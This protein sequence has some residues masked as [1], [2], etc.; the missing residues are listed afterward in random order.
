MEF[1]IDTKRIELD[2]EENREDNDIGQ[3]RLTLNDNYG[4]YYMQVFLDTEQIRDLIDG[5][6]PLDKQIPKNEY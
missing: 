4:H 3:Y 1:L 2:Y 5:L 6:L